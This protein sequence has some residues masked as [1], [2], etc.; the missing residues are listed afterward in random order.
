MTAM[1]LPGMTWPVRHEV[2]SSLVL[3]P[4]WE[5]QQDPY[6]IVGGLRAIGRAEWRTHISRQKTV[7]ET[8]GCKKNVGTSVS[9]N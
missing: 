8:S 1:P 5:S 9:H 2:G 6:V 3:Y 7:R 4:L